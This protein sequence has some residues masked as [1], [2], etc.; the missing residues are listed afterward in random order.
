MNRFEKY[1]GR[2]RMTPQRYNTDELQELYISKYNLWDMAVK[3]Q[4]PKT[5][6]TYINF[7]R[8]SGT[9]IHC[10]IEQFLKILKQ[11]IEQAIPPSKLN[12]VLQKLETELIECEFSCPCPSEP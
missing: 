2:I 1:D 10:P 4:M 7:L 11:I 5:S 3:T 8:K 9:P 6:S 12:D